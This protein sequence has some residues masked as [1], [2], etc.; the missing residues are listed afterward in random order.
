[1]S[2]F[3]PDDLPPLENARGRKF[4]IQHSPDDRVC[5]FRMAQDAEKQLTEKGAA[6]KFTE[7]QG[8]HGWNGN[9]F[10]NMRSNLDWL[11]Q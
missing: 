1:M 3:K 7:T 11:A 2:V 5:P 8:G 4:A 9:V 6:V 10:G